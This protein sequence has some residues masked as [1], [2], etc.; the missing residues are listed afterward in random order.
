[1]KVDFWSQIKYRQKL[2]LLIILLILLTNGYTLKYL[3]LALSFFTHKRQV[4]KNT[5]YMIK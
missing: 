3:N 1:M 5:I 2:T 4:E